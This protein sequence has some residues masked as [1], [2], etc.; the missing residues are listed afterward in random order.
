MDRK[1]KV[2]A[3]MA[4]PGRAVDSL[5]TVIGTVIES[6]R[7]P[8]DPS[9]RTP[10][11]TPSDPSLLTAGKQRLQDLSRSEGEHRLDVVDT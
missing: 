4:P 6:L 10:R 7:T 2:P 1:R 8:I 5:R 3:V 9:V 11:R